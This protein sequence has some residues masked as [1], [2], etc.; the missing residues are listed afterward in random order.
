MGPFGLTGASAT[1]TVA[2]GSSFPDVAFGRVRRPCPFGRVVRLVFSRRSPQVTRCLAS[3]TNALRLGPVDSRS[4]GRERPARDRRAVPPDRDRA[5]PTVARRARCRRARCWRHTSTGSSGSTRASTPSSR[6]RPSAP[7]TR[8]RPPTSA[9]ARGASAGTAPRAA[10]GRQGPPPDRRH[11]HHLRLAPVRRLR[12]AGRLPARRPGAGRGRHRGRQDQRARVRCRQPDVQHD[13]RRHPQPLRPHQDLR[14]Q[15]RRRSRGPGLWDGPARRRQRHG[16]VAPQPGQLLQRGRSAPV[17][18]A[19]ALLAGAARLADVG[20]G[21]SHGPHRGRRGPAPERRGRAR[22]PLPDQPRRGRRPLPPT[23]RPRPPGH[24]GRLGHAGAPVRTGRPRGGR[25]HPLDVRGARLHRRGR[26]ARP[27]QRRRHLPRLA[28]A[29]HAGAAGPGR[30]RPGAAAPAE[31]HPALERG[32]GRPPDRAAA[33]QRGAGPDRAVPAD[34]R[35]HDHATTCS[36]CP[37]ARC[38]PST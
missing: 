25:R 33:G 5:G 23:A 36:C 35:V 34:A 6:S 32:A 17:A 30:R 3:A 14:R 15:Q 18:G 7:P 19:G 26:R 37:S 38:C 29:D 13:L 12:A 1:S 9:L 28:G 10:A 22:Q 11:P 20:R 27:H 24:E 21:G 16:W 4:S 2:T 8:P 31:G